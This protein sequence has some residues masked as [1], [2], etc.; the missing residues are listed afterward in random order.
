MSGLFGEALKPV[1]PNWLKSYWPLFLAVAGLLAFTIQNPILGLSSIVGFF[2]RAG[3]PAWP[4]LAVLMESIYQTVFMAVVGTSLGFLIAFI[5]ACEITLTQNRRLRLI[6]GIPVLGLRGLPDL[7]AALIISQIIGVGLVAGTLAISLGTIGVSTKLISNIFN[8]SSSDARLWL[9]RAGNGKRRAFYIGELPQHLRELRAQFF[10]RMEINFR[11]ATIIG[12]A[13]GGGL[14]LILRIN[15]GQFDFSASSA[16]ILVLAVVILF[17]ELLTRFAIRGK[18]PHSRAGTRLSSSWILAFPAFWLTTSVL[19]VFWELQRTEVRFDVAQATRTLGQLLQPDFFS[20]GFPLLQGLSETLIMAILGSLVAFP[21]AVM[22]G[23]LSSTAI[24]APK[25][26][27]FL[28]R[29]LLGALRSIPTAVLGLILVF[30]M[31]LGFGTGLFALSLGSTLFLSRLFRDA[32]DSKAK[33]SV[34]SFVKAG[35]TSYQGLIAVMRGQLRSRLFEL[36]L[37]TVDFN[38][39]YTVVLGLIGAGGLGTVISSSLRVMDLGTASAATLII[40]LLLFGL[41]FAANRR[42]SLRSV[43]AH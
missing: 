39:R 11:I 18:G 19:L 13:G 37:F 25:G 24:S 6:L 10:F 1:A 28:I 2:Q 21:V 4:P 22:L 27:G 17:T 9:E 12:I 3:T 7:V 35:A 42:H 14:G 43:T 29:V 41:E 15:L 5:V 16:I 23:A 30:E 31:G 33:E 20:Q 36:A 8:K 40:I 32:F 38:L 34:D 26:L